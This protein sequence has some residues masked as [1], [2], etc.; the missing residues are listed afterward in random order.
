MRLSDGVSIR[1][2]TAPHFVATKI[3]AFKGRGDG[4]F[5][6][7]RD[8]EDI[9]AVVDGRQEIVDEALRSSPALRAYL[10]RELGAWLDDHDFE[11]VVPGHLPGDEASQAR[12]RIVLE[13]LERLA[14]RTRRPSR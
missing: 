5:V 11:A 12:A 10:Q 9:L 6:T 14:G 7:S 1:V 4:D 2:V 3:E 8:V 13:R